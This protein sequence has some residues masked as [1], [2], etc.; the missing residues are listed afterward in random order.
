V[1]PKRFQAGKKTKRGGD[2][3]VVG[4]SSCLS[5]A[6]TGM[7]LN[8]QQVISTQVP[9]TYYKEQIN[10]DVDKLQQYSSSQMTGI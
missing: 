3:D 8:F 4:N 1:H 5:V 2:W 6:L 10:A 7:L 9:S